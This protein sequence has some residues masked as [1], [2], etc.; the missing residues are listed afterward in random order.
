[1]Q[2]NS[3]KVVILTGATSGIGEKLAIKLINSNYKLIILY[4]NKQ[5]SQNLINKINNLLSNKEED[6]RKRIDLIECDLGSLKNIENAI[7]IIK[8]NYDKIDVLINNAGVFCWKRELSEDGFEKTMAIDYI[9][10]AKLTL[11]VLDLIKNSIGGKIINVSSNIHKY[12]GINF[13]DIMSERKYNS[14][15]A[16]SNAKAALVLFTFKL[17]RLLNQTDDIKI[18]INAIHPG[19]VRT[20]M[21][22][23]GAP[24]IFRI[25]S[26]LIPIYINVEDV[27]SNIFNLLVHPEF[28]RLSGVYFEKNKIGKPHKKMNSLELQDKLWNLTLDWISGQ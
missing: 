12:F 17:H 21:I 9:A 7:K 2:R 4:R 16:Y 26:R 11:G 24:K 28:S 14:Q 19:H 8:R 15:I 10:H 1:M 18:F 20:N 13:D 5:K 3:N 22:I 6:V 23:S 25:F 27:A